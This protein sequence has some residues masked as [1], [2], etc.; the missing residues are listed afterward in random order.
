MSDLVYQ[1]YNNKCKGWVNPSNLFFGPEITGL[2]GYQSPAGSNTVV[3]IIG[4]NFYSYSVIRFGTFTPTTYFINSTLLSFYVPSTLTSGNFPVQV[5]NG[6]VGSNIVNYTIDMASGYWMINSGLNT[7]TITNTNPNGVQVSWLSR[8]GIIL[9]SNTGETP[10]PYGTAENAISITN[11]MNWIKCDG[12][13]NK[14]TTYLSLPNGT[15]YIGRELT[16]KSISGDVYSGTLNVIIPLSG[17]GYQSLIT[18]EGSW[19]TLINTNGSN[20]EIMQQGS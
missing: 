1:N 18:Q 20:W 3:T 19:V 13:T 14:N 12:G 11:N 8:N 7:N 5:Y 2:T 16:V 10:G 6:S 4:T 17:N 9:V 15:M